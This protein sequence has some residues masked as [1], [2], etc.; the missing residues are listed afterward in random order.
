MLSI[1]FLLFLVNAEINLDVPLIQ[2]C[3]SGKRF[4][5]NHIMY[6]CHQFGERRSFRPFACATENDL[7]TAEFIGQNTTHNE[8][9]FRYKCERIGR[10]LTYKPLTCLLSDV[11]LTPG[12]T[13]RR[14]QTEYTCLLDNQFYMKLIQ[15][16]NLHNLLLVLHEFCMPGNQNDSLLE[17]DRCPGISIGATH[18]KFG[19]GTEVVYDFQYKTIVDVDNLI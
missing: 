2:D 17:D 4:I 10:K 14:G 9:F 13:I 12:M 8:R 1:F 5:V 3:T 15:K 7:Q 19:S 11:H 18:A 16:R 6:L